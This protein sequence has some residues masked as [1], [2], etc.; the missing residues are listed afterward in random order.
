MT[1]LMLFC[2]MFTYGAAAEQSAWAMY[3]PDLAGTVPGWWS[4][5]AIMNIS[6]TAIDDCKILIVECDG[7][8]KG[9]YT[10][11][12]AANDIYAP[13]IANLMAALTPDPSNPGTLGD[14]NCM[15]LVY[16]E[17]TSG[18]KNAD[19]LYAFS[20]AGNGTEGFAAFAFKFYESNA[21]GTQRD[22][23][24]SLPLDGSIPGWWQGFLVFLIPPQFFSGIS[25]DAD[26]GA[27]VQ[28][29]NLTFTL[30][31]EDGDKGAYTSSFTYGF[32]NPGVMADFLAEFTA[33]AGNSG[34][35]GDARGRITCEF[36]DSG[37][38]SFWSMLGNGTEGMT[39]R[40]HGCM[41]KN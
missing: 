14:A 15:I 18:Y 27:T 13:E 16:Q 5:L 3:A 33:D 4:G 24:F 28:S 35:L 40:P 17:S 38:M 41:M 32:Y 29:S 8:D 1:A 9:T 7:V 37:I 36:T 23:L 12:I 21:T 2:V 34:T 22:H 26:W 10:V 11:S 19:N 25:T 30:Y 39:V 6:S 20:M 31:E